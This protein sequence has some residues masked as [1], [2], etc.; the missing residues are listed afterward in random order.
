MAHAGEDQLAAADLER[1][2][3]RRRRR[4]ARRGR[5]P[6]AGRAR[7]RRRRRARSRRGAGCA[8]RRR[9]RRR[10]ARPSR[11]ASARSWRRG[12]GPTPRGDY[13]HTLGRPPA[14]AAR[15]GRAR[16]DA[17]VDRQHLLVGLAEEEALAEVDAELLDVLELVVALDA[18]GDD[19]D[20]ELVGDLDERADE[21][22]ARR[23]GLDALAQVQRQLGDVG[24]APRGRVSASVPTERSSREMIAP[25]SR[26]AATSSTSSSRSAKRSAP[27]SSRPTRSAA[28]AG[29]LDLVPD[30]AQRALDVE[31][32]ARVELDEQ[33]LAVGQA[34]QAGLERRPRGRGRRRRRARRGP[35]RPRAAPGRGPRPCPCGRGSAPRGRR[36]SRRQVDE[37]LEDRGQLALGEELRE[38]VGARAVEQRSW[39]GA[40]APAGRRGG[41]RTAAR[42]RRCRRS[43]MSSR[44]RSPQPGPESST[45]STETSA[46]S[47][48][49]PRCS[50]L[51]STDGRCDSSRTPSP[52]AGHRSMYPARLTMRSIGTAG[53]PTP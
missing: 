40:A 52:V 26:W 51:N 30:G 49:S 37:R 45:P 16:D 38:P 44:R 17:A 10:R 39:R 25:R 24:R 41:P 14:D 27:I 1:E 50:S 19:A 48:W 32:R 29:A 53:R 21:V 33:D 7:R 46:S 6:A 8:C 36:P 43:P 31:H 3:A 47:G 28:A 9:R 18:D 11:A 35:R 23:R 13:A 12:R 22:A 34:R 15:R 20:A 5:S 2:V 4:R 42:A